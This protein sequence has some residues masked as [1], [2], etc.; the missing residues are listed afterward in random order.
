MLQCV[1]GNHS[2][3]RLANAKRLAMNAPLRKTRR[4]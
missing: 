4:K 1:N 2:G 3:T